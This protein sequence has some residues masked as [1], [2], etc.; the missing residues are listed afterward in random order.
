MIELLIELYCW[1][2]LESKR[3]WWFDTWIAHHYFDI[4][5]HFWKKKNKMKDLGIHLLWIINFDK[6]GNFGESYA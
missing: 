2:N 4:S 3:I 6:F 5:T 1:I